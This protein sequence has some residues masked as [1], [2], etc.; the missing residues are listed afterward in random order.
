[1][2]FN[3]NS[4]GSPT[5]VSLGALGGLIAVACPSVSQCTAIDDVFEELTFNPSSPGTLTFADISDINST[6]ATYPTTIVC[7]S[8]GQCTVVD[9]SGSELTFDP[10][11]SD[12]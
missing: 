1:V 3:L 5:P 12:T 11:S 4:P 8:V 9:D 7:P 10:D 2:T 6:N